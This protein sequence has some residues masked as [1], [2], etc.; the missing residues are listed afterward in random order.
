MTLINI[1]K[2]I[3]ILPDVFLVFQWTVTR[4]SSAAQKRGASF[5]PKAPGLLLLKPLHEQTKVYV[6]FVNIFCPV[7]FDLSLLFH[8]IPGFNPGLLMFDSVVSSF[9]SSLKVFN[10]TLI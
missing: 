3:T 8:F 2:S 6:T 5:A 4:E 10:P 9:S 1:F 7:E